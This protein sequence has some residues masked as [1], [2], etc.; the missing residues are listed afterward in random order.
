MKDKPLEEII[1]EEITELRKQSFIVGYD[2]GYDMG[3]LDAASVSIASRIGYTKISGEKAW[4]LIQA[5]IIENKLK[6]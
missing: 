4:E 6:P 1:N 5:Q 3:M 2:R